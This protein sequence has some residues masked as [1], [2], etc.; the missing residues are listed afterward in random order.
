MKQ[1]QW[2]VKIDPRVRRI[3]CTARIEDRI[4][5]GATRARSEFYIYL[6][7][8][9][10]AD[11]FAEKV[12]VWEKRPGKAV[13]QGNTYPD[14]IVGV[15]A[16]S[17]ISAMKHDDEEFAP[18]LVRD[19]EHLGPMFSDK[20]KSLSDIRILLGF[21]Q[22]FHVLYKSVRGG[23][24]KPF[25][26]IVEFLYRPYCKA[27]ESFPDHDGAWMLSYSMG[28]IEVIPQRR[29]TV[30][31]LI[32]PKEIE[33]KIVENRPYSNENEIQK[34]AEK[35]IVFNL[36]R[37]IKKHVNY[38]T[39]I[40]PNQGLTIT[41]SPVDRFTAALLEV[42]GPDIN[43]DFCRGCPRLEH[44]GQSSRLNIRRSVVQRFRTWKKRGRIT[45]EQFDSI[46]AYSSELIDSDREFTKD[47]LWEELIRY[48]GE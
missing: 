44:E 41:V 21:Y 34:W 46:L 11:P 13:R 28:D 27:L 22:I 6:G 17:M 35:I 9:P 25:M 30:D 33:P 24:E 45:Q 2:P 16:L 42:V 38:K 36:D 26:M 39:E 1:K 19:Y 43:M 12:L 4:M 48:I 20:E 32:I 29:R 37:Y 40:K 47:E 14:F 10:P 18:Y 23:Y 5:A 31:G 7:K 3:E 8:T 15:T